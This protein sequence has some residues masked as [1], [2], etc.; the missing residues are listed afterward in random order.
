[1]AIVDRVRE[2][3]HAKTRLDAL[4]TILTHFE[5]L[6]KLDV[7]A[8]LILKTTRNGSQIFLEKKNGKVYNV[9]DLVRKLAERATAASKT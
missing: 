1:M 3:T 6:E 8:K 4:A 5:P 9:T 7:L 2:R